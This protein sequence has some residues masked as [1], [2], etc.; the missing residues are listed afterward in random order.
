MPM[1]S[2]PLWGK[3]LGGLA[4][5]SV[6]GGALYV[7][8]SSEVAYVPQ[9]PVDLERRLLLN[10]KPVPPLA[11]HLYAAGVERRTLS[12]AE[13]AALLADPRVDFEPAG[14]PASPPSADDMRVAGA[15]GLQLAGLGGDPFSGTGAIVTGVD[16]GTL[17]AGLLRNG[18]I[19]VVVD[20]VPVDDS[21]ALLA[22]LRGRVPG[23][24]Y[25]LGVRRAQRTV[26]AN[27]RT[28]PVTAADPPSTRSRPGFSVET[29]SLRVQSARP[30]AVRG[31]PA[32]LAGSALAVALYV[33]DVESSTDL[34]RGRFVVATGDVTPDGHVQ[35]PGQVRQRA[36]AAQESRRDLLLV[37]AAT[38][39]VARDAVESAC[40]EG[41]DCV[42]VVPVRSVD[43]AVALLKVTD[44]QLAARLQ[45]ATAP[46]AARS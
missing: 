45:A 27:L 25:R 37:P 11:G 15:L 9:A 3:L 14:P 31:R 12:L 28:L 5:V 18:D 6:A 36:I 38:A 21:A 23:S 26:V 2:I 30:V 34:L 1:R 35:D 40:G 4:L 32:A 43:E 7:A 20:E 46:G 33:Y 41:E 10:G 22:N 16:A 39:K 44:A 24:P 13:R 29:A 8:P 19:I 42:Q 17:A